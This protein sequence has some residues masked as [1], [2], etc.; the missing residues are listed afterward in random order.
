MVSLVQAQ[1]V[2]SGERITPTRCVAGGLSTH[3]TEVMKALSAT[4][5]IVRIW[6]EP[7]AAT[8]VWRASVTNVRSEEKQYFQDPNELARFIAE[9]MLTSSETGKPNARGR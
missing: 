7:S 1:W 3:G 9:N 6:L 2:S 8:G 5:L 4:T